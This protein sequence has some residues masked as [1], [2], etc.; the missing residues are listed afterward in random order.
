MSLIKC[1]ECGK[2]ISSLAKA[3]PHC[4]CPVTEPESVPST[5]T[6]TPKTNVPK[7]KGGCLKYFFITIIVL[8][9]I[10]FGVSVLLLSVTPSTS[11]TGS[12][13]DVTDEQS[14]NIDSVLESC[15]VV[16]V[17]AIEH[18]ELLD[19]AHMDGET[20]YR[21]TANGDDNIIMYLDSDMN[22]YSIRYADYDLYAD[23][24]V[25]STLNDYCFTTEELTDWQIKCQDKIKEL[26]VSPST[27]KF[28]NILNWGFSKNKNIITVQSYVDSQNGFGAMIRSEFQFIIDT[29][30]DT[31]Q[32][33]IFDGQEMIAQ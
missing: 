33:L 27:A 20:G 14:N 3:C 18:D 8:A 28:P 22:V 30:S 5:P 6:E 29:D 9:F 31:I 4:G 17:T 1:K 24:T 13:I 16:N 11:T 2:E 21:I 7:K 32:S 25:V 19:N 23:G 10:S 26:L 15:G 12:Y